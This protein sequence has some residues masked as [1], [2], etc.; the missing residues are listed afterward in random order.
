MYAPKHSKHTTTFRLSLF[1]DDN[2]FYYEIKM[3]V[4]LIQ[5][6]PD[7]YFISKVKVN[8]SLLMDFS[9][10][11]IQICLENASPN[12]MFKCNV[13]IHQKKTISKASILLITNRQ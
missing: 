11:F 12:H 1:D 10:S 3:N 6:D 5:I 9:S 2:N 13:S 4:F 8:H 7:A